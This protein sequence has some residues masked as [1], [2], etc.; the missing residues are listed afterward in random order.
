LAS[1]INGC[2]ATIAEVSS[3]EDTVGRD[4]NN[5]PAL[6]ERRLNE[7]V[8]FRPTV[9]T[10]PAAAKVL[11]WCARQVE[12][13]R[14][15][16]S[17]LDEI[18]RIAFDRAEALGPRR[19]TEVSCS[20]SILLDLGAQGWSVTVERGQI[21]VVPPTAADGNASRKAQVRAS[22]HI[23]R[24]AQLATPAV[25]RFIRE[26]E[27]QRPHKGEWHSIF[28]LMR[29]GRDLAAVLETARSAPEESR[30]AALEAALDPYVQAATTNAVCSLTGIRLLDAWRY[31]RHTWSTSYKNT[32]GRKMYFLIRDRAAPN[33]PVIGIGALGSAIVQLGARDEWIGWTGEKVLANLDANPS[34]SWAAWVDRTLADLIAGHRVDDLLRAARLPARVLQHPTERG[35]EKLR[36]IARRSRAQHRLLPQRSRHKTASTA[37]KADWHDLSSTHLFRAKRAE[38][39]VALLEARLQLREAGFTVPSSSALTKA[40]THRAARKAIKTLVRYTKARHAGVDMMDI[41]VC[42][43]IAPYNAVLGGKLVSLLMASPDVIA[44]YGDRYRHACSVIASSMAGKAATR[45]P[46]LVLLGTTSLYD[47]ASSQY[48]RLVVPRQALGDAPA[49]L[50]FMNIGSTEGYGSH[51]FSVP[52]MKLLE[53]VTARTQSGRRVNSIFGEGVNPKLRK[54]REALDTLG[55]KSD[56]L[57]QHGSPRIIYAVP[58][59]TNFREILLGYERRPN[60][61]LPPAGTGTELITA[62]WR[63]RWLSR[64]ISQPAVL[65][66]ISGHTLAHPIMHGARVRLPLV[67][68]D[69]PLFRR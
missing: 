23:E 10:N 46:N 44:A 64:R 50:E 12:A 4:A 51:Q 27:R 40:L 36:A 67:D 26:M 35:L 57:L 21:L 54:V 25:R 62:Y 61:I 22:H 30:D 49:G 56:G 38:A 2:S 69:G 37:T 66:A 8:V 63:R 1:P 19:G 41:T 47:V 58:L 59:A 13:R 53:R 24:D 48:N 5:G 68:D 39:V 52:T 15:D 65:T 55:L 43:A 60:Y 9:M 6:S 29:D 45:K 3:L 7:T 34:A 33:H 28:S 11:R 18:R 42:G 20:A 16:R 31:F 14:G 17:A 32:P